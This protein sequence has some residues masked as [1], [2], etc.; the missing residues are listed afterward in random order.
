MYPQMTPILICTSPRNVREGGLFRSVAENSR[1]IFNFS[2][3]RW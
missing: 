3:I 2:R 1:T